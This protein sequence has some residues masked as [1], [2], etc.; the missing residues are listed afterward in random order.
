MDWQEYF[1]PHILSR[2]YEYYRRGLVKDVKVTDT[3]VSAVVKGSEDYMVQI[4]RTDDDEFDPDMYCTCPYADGGNLCKHMAAVLFQ[5][6]DLL[7]PEESNDEEEKS[8]PADTTGKAGAKHTSEKLSPGIKR[9]TPADLVQ[10]AD[11]KTVRSFLLQVLK[12]DEK[13]AIQFE[14]LLYPATSSSDVARL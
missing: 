3:A 11:E 4:D 12:D 8:I 10:Q 2:G 7:W 13:L 6:E 14:N 9:K 5:V 1:Q